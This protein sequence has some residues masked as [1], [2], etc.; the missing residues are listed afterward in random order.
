[1]NTTIRMCLA[2]ALVCV[3][4]LT[5]AQSEREKY[6]QV[7]TERSDKI[8]A[9][10]GDLDREKYAEARAIVVRQ[11]D[12]LNSHHEARDGKIKQLKDTYGG[13][14]ALLEEKRDELERKEDSVLRVLHADFLH[15]LGQVLTPKQIDQVKDGMTY[16]VLPLTYKAYQE[17]IPQLTEAQKAQIFSYLIEARELAM[18]APGSKEKHGVFGKYKGRINNYLSKEGYDLKEEGKKWEERRAKAKVD[19][20]S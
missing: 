5:Y 10:L 8:I 4:K 9:Q 7:I 3:L 16:G 15:K 1:M 6:L 11:Y 2:L 13:R 19:T 17:M 20:K 12:L 18:D 14:P